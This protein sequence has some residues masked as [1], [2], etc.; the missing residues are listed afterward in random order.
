MT[1]ASSQRG[2]WLLR[3]S[4]PPQKA[5]HDIFISHVPKSNTITSA[6]L[7]IEAIIEV[8]HASGGKEHRLYHSRRMSMSRKKNTGVRTY[9]DILDWAST[10]SYSVVTFINFKRFTLYWFSFAYFIVIS[11][12]YP[13]LIYMKWNLFVTCF[14]S[15]PTRSVSPYSVWFLSSLLPATFWLSS[16]QFFPILLSLLFFFSSRPLSLYPTYLVTLL[17]SLPHP[18]LSFPLTTPSGLQKDLKTL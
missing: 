9:W 2:D 8:C 18:S 16:A 15:P 10:I 4:I 3:A 11:I 1:W 17:I 7:L 5:V 6:V 14:T 13:P 12:P